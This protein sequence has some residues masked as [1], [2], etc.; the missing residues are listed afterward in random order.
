[1]RKARMVQPHLI[2]ARIVSE[3]DLL[4]M[5]ARF[6][7]LEGRVNTTA[8]EKP[9]SDHDS[10]D[11]NLYHGEILQIRSTIASISPT[12]ALLVDQPTTQTTQLLVRLA[13]LKL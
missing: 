10:K 11:G 13:S 7:C 2:S 3:T 4:R 6:G 9:Q 5:V 12:P 8:R 1:M